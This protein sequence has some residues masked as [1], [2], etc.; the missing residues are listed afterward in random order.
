MRRQRR[1]RDGHSEDDYGRWRG[2]SL[3]RRRRLWRRAGWGSVAARLA[4][5]MAHGRTH[6]MP[7]DASEL[8]SD[9]RSALDHARDDGELEGCLVDV[10][11]GGVEPPRADRLKR[12]SDRSNDCLKVLVPM[13][14]ISLLWALS[15]L[16]FFPLAESS[17]LTVCNSIGT[18]R[19]CDNH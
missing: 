1:C 3:P 16:I 7:H 13:T 15:G 2:L 14:P 10:S 17:E 4:A 5:A 9:S 18:N 12:A 8:A 11:G 6:A 19:A